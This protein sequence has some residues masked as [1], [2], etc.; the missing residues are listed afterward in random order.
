MPYKRD[1]T[2]IESTH[3]VAVPAPGLTDVILKPAPFSLPVTP[4]QFSR[5]VTPA[6]LSF[7]VVPATFSFPITP[8]SGEFARAPSS[9][10]VTRSLPV[11]QPERFGSS[12]PGQPRSVSPG[13]TFP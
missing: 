4:E 6:T 5:P 10:P 7:T 1:T 13:L 3:P 2:G 9:F 11:T 12:Y 8:S